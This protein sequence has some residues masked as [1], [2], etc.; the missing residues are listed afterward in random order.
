[1]RGNFP[2]KNE[3]YVLPDGEVIITRTDN[4]S[5]ITYANEAFVRSSG[6]S[7][8]EII[9]EPQNIVR[10][11]DMPAKAFEDMWAT[12]QDDRPW[13]GVVKNRRRD[14]GFYWVVANV[15]PVFKSGQ[16][17]GYM[18]VRTK[19]SRE[20]VATATELYRRIREG[21]DKYFR[22]H[23]GEVR[24]VGL[25]GLSSRILGLP[26]G[27]RLWAVMLVLVGIL[28]AQAIGVSLL[29]AEAGIFVEG[30][31]M[32]TASGVVIGLGAAFYLSRQV[33]EPLKRLNETAF[34]VSSGQVQARF[35]ERGDVQAKMLGRVLNQMNAKLVGV[36]LDA[37]VAVDTIRVAAANQER[38]NADLSRRNEETASSIEETTGSLSQI[39]ETARQNALGA[40]HVNE[41]AQAAS[42][43]AMS[44][45]SDVR[46]LANLMGDL[47]RQSRK[48]A[49]ITSMIDGIAFQTNIL[50]LNAAVEAARAGESGRSFSVVATE[51][52]GLST[53]TASAAKEIKLLIDD[54]NQAISKAGAV[55]VCAGGAMAGVEEKVRALMESVSVIASASRE[56]SQEIGHI[57][58]AVG[59]VA[60]LTQRN[61]GLVEQ[62]AESASRLGQQAQHLEDCVNVFML[63]E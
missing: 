6:F 1:M 58:L 31:W 40:E 59:Q 50:A 11:P 38:G 29:K 17:V 2:V 43:A 23:H 28:L 7:R 46:K 19:P 37:R 4:F 12:L 55:A 41:A 3:E 48:I 63:T 24:R 60:Q 9:G 52:R 16:K 5:R 33:L 44:A 20:Q 27:I 47:D 25:A 42:S 22:L 15:T 26:V 57:D 35:P 18:S 49:E 62:A 45:A 13:T 54:S 32:L 53:K 30:I 39:T 61:A 8:A 51:V 14:G 36:L 56:Q 34:A 21:E 10:H